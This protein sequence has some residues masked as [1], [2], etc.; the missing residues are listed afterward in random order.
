[1]LCLLCAFGGGLAAQVVA[2]ADAAN[3]ASLAA[4]IDRYRTVTWHWQRVMGVPRTPASRTDH[5]TSDPAYRRWVLALWQR[6]AA[7]VQRRAA[8]WLT[9]RAATYR[10]TVRHWQRVMG[11][12]PEPVRQVASAAS[13]LEARLA[14]LRVWHAR[15]EQ[16][17]R[18]AQNPPHKQAWLCIHRH[19]GRWTD[20]G[21]PYYGG[22]QM[23]LTFQRH[24]GSYLL[25]SKGTADAWTPLEQI[26]VAVRAYRSGR[27]FGPWPNT[28][29]ACGVR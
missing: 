27:G 20:G 22:L 4:Q 29:R 9:A 2:R 26:W 21:S 8:D 16:I 23:D 17:L 14:R 6:R 18:R 19:E 15:A 25:R 24:Y 10:R 28:A 13:G 12:A 3:R 1:M 7:R 5:S 11:V